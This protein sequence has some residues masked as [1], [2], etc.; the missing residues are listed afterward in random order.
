M[1][2]K[3]YLTDHW[4]GPAKRTVFVNGEYIVNKLLT[5]I[6]HSFT[7]VFFIKRTFEIES[8]PLHVDQKI[9]SIN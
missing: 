9:H 7:P 4:S 5:T 6:T 1:T 8:S 2:S 3:Q